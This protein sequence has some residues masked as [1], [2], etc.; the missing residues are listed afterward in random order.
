M[1]PPGRT[2]R[3]VGGASWC[4]CDID[5][6]GGEGANRTS[7]P[8]GLDLVSD[9]GRGCLLR[10]GYTQPNGQPAPD[11]DGHTQP[12]GRHEQRRAGDAVTDRDTQPNGQPAPDGAGH[13]KA[14]PGHD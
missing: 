4:D 10:H 5:D 7:G 2:T 12:D 8:N 9:A 3:A 6:L 11:G 13:G 1:A 14:R